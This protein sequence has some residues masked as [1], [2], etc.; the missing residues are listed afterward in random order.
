MVPEGLLPCSQE[1][2]TGPHPE[3]DQSSL[4]NPIVTKI[5]VNIIRQPTFSLSSGLFTSGYRAKL[6]VHSSYPHLCYIS[7]QSHPRFNFVTF[8]TKCMFIIRS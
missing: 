2:S 4:Y 1:P 8:V 7:C 3:S 5:H 6:Y